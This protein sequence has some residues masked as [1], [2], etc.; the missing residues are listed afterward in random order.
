MCFLEYQHL[1]ATNHW[2]TEHLSAEAAPGTFAG[3]SKIDAPVMV[4]DRKDDVVPVAAVISHATEV[5]MQ[6]LRDLRLDVAFGV[7]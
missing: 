1:Y 6:P 2:R 4:A 7:Q 3:K 5:R